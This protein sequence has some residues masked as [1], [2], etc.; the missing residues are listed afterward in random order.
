MAIQFFIGAS[1]SAFMVIRYLC[2]KI[3]PLLYVSLNN[4]VTR[5]YTLSGGTFGD[6]PQLYVYFDLPL[7]PVIYP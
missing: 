1:M 6:A 4:S 2:F 7:N 5:P 3:R